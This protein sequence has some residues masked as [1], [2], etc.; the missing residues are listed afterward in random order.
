MNTAAKSISRLKNIY[1]NEIVFTE[2]NSNKRIE[3][4]MTFILVFKEQ[5]PGRKY[6]VNESAFVPAHK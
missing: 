3:G 5:D 4:D 6:W 2:K 1:T